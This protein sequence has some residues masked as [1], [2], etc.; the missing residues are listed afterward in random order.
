MLTSHRRILQKNVQ[1]ATAV[2]DVTRQFS[3][4]PSVRSAFSSNASGSEAPRG[5]RVAGCFANTC[6][7]EILHPQPYRVPAC[8]PDNRTNMEP[9]N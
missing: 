4:P 6:C 2:Y 1:H 5:T 7:S 3:E 9:Q 8:A